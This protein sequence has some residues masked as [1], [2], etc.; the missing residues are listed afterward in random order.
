MILM[1]RNA[2]SKVQTLRKMRENFAV[3]QRTDWRLEWSFLANF[4]QKFSMFLVQNKSFVPWKLNFEA[5]IGPN[6]L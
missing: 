3:F 6:C 4:E 1:K 2:P 5:K